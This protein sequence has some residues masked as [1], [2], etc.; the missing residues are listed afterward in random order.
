[1]S[2]SARA[3]RR[4]PRRLAIVMLAVLL[5][6]TMIVIMSL[7]ARDASAHGTVINPMTRNYGCLQRWTT[8]GA[9]F[10]DPAMAQKD[11]MCW[12]AWQADP[13]AM[14]NWNGL[15]QD[16]VG[17]RTSSYTGETGLTPQDVIPNHMRAVPDGQ[18]CSGGHAAA[19]RYNALDKPGNWTA[20]PLPNQFTMTLHDGARHGSD[21]N[22]VYIT[23]QG[24]DVQTQPLRWSD[25]D[26]VKVGPRVMPGAGTPG[27][28]QQD[29]GVNVGID[30]NA[31]NRTGR[32]IVFTIWQ[33]SHS[34]QSYYLCSDVQFGGGGTTP[35][36]TPT[37]TTTWAQP[38]TT[39][40]PG[41]TTT[42]RP[43]PTTGQPPV[44]PPPT[45]GTKA[46]AASYKLVS[47]WPAG[48]Q[49]EVTVTAGAAA[50][51][52]WTVTAAFPD[53][54]SITQAWNSTVTGTGSTVAVKNAAWNGGVAPGGSTTFGFLGRGTGNGAPT[55]TCVPA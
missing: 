17:G 46:C 35:T 52:G 10:Q 21:Y 49:G 44:T 1:M 14:W 39:V 37:P 5:P 45:P 2:I 38:T 15:Y 9:S 48:F 13:S 16:N 51:T 27:A 25:L 26:L 28:I 12:Q 54:Q 33:A 41:P 50:L 4:R 53:G 40:R 20:T 24:F 22:L 32:H 19:G 7:K 8:N 55:L 30:V 11:P 42:A 36:T 3:I 29:G 18:L 23:K 47:S 31:G 34:D 6:A 43:T